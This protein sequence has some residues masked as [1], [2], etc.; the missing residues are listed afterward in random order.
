MKKLWQ[1]IE[2]CQKKFD[3]YLDLKWA[4]MDINEMED[5]I[6]KMRLRYADK[7]GEEKKLEG[8]N[9]TTV[10]MAAEIEALRSRIEEKNMTA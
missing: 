10:L 1:H 4:Q 5:D 6:K 3:D 8:F 7:I 2:K 9:L